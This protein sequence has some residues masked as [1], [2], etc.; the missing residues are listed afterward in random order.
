MKATTWLRTAIITVIVLGASAVQAQVN[1]G[2]SGIALNATLPEQITVTLSPL[3]PTVNFGNLTPLSGTNAGDITVDVTTRWA[4]SPARTNLQLY[5]W[6]ASSAEALGGTG[7]NDIPSSAFEIDVNGGGFNAVIGAG[8][9]GGASL[10]LFSINIIGNNKNGT[11]TDTLSFN[12]DLSAPALSSLA[13]DT[14]TGT[15]NIQAQAIT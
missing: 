3:G 7:T 5:A 2:A 9:F 4:L 8:P 12:I 14:F 10:S 11:R 13:A 15:L 6:F 1:S